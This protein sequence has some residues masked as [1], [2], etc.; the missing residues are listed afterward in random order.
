M[1][2]LQINVEKTEDGKYSV[3]GIICSKKAW[4]RMLTKRLKCEVSFSDA[5]GLKQLMY[6]LVYSGENI[7]SLQEEGF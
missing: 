5:G 3:N 1:T 4:E 6:A 7:D 2:E